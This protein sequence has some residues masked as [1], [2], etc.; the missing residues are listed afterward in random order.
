VWNIRHPADAVTGLLSASCEIERSSEVCSRVCQHLEIDLMG[1][2]AGQHGALRV[3]ARISL[4][5]RYRVS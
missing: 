4:A 2:H 5:P 3:C 1:V